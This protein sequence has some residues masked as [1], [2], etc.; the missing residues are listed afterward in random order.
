MNEKTIKMSDGFSIHTVFTRPSDRPLAHIHLL[1]GMAEHIGRYKEFMAYLADEGFAVSAHDHRGHGQTATLNGKLGHFGDS[2]GFDRIV[3]DAH[4]IIGFYRNEFQTPKL[5]LFGHSMGS[6]VARRYAQRYG[7][8][9]YKL[10]C[11]G[12]AGDPGL[13]RVGGQ[14]IAYLKGKATKFDEPDYF[15]NKLVFGAFNKT[16]S[17]PR[18]PFDWL[19]KDKETVE[20][21]IND[22]LCGFVPTTRFFI[23]LFDGLAKINDREKIREIPSGL[24]ILLLSGLD[25]PV[26]LKGK[27]VWQAAEQFT[28]VGITNITVMLYEGGRHEMLNEVN[29]KQV[30][31]FITDW[32]IE[33]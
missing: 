1:H 28:D 23:D 33:E 8:D 16:V 18:T 29:R 7:N 26:G 17:E 19:T 2:T 4:E 14:A 11:S 3:E 6:F 32:I 13:S 22:P 10:I 12:T 9:L 21:Y 24:P 25:D 5:I 27:G 31:N 15:I 20:R 30:F